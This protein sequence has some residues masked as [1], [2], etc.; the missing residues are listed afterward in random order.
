MGYNATTGFQTT[1]KD[2]YGNTTTIAYDSVGHVATITYPPAQQGQSSYVKTFMYSTPISIDSNVTQVQETVTDQQNATT[3]YLYTDTDNPCLPTS[4]TN[5]LNQT[6]TKQY[7]SHGQVTS[8]TQPTTG[9]TKTTQYSYSPT[10]GDLVKK[11]DALGN[12]TQY[13]RNLNG[14]ASEIKVY[15]GTVSTGT[16]VADTTISLSVLNTSTGTSDSVSGLT[17]AQSDNANGAT[18]ST[19]STLG[20]TNSVSLKDAMQA[21]MPSKMFMRAPSKNIGSIQFPTIPAPRFPMDPYQPLPASSTN[22][23]GNVTT[24]VYKNNGTISTTINHLAQATNYSYDL[25]GRTSGVADPF[26]KNTSYGYDLNSQ[27]L[28]KTVTGEGTTSYVYD[29]VHNLQQITEPIKGTNTLTRNL[30]GRFGTGY[31]CF[32]F[33]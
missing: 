16:L 2:S 1:S 23:Q 12:E 14:L 9:G 8:V 26:G 20:C 24:Y 22:T 25:F 7:N 10:T 32:L 30:P 5:P 29:N 31:L 17:S 11:T 4:I 33:P 13:L 27:L 21:S 6:A 18:L 28:S 19:T 15:D 3:S